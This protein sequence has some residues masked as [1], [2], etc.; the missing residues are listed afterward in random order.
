MLTFLTRRFL[1]AAALYAVVALVCTQIPL[2]NYLGYEYS[3]VIGFVGAFVAGF[4][5]IRITGEVYHREEGSTPG[6]VLDAFTKSVRANLLL[7]IIPLIIIL[8][9][10][11]FVK[12]CSLMQGFAFFLLLPMVSVLFGSALGFYCTI[13]Y[14][15]P[16]VMFLFYAAAFILYSLAEGY[17]TPAIFSYNFLYGYFP[18]LSYDEVLRITPSLVFFRVL[19]LG[20]SGLFVWWGVVLLTTTA[21]HDSVV[22]KGKTLALALLSRGRLAAMVCVVAV[23]VLLWFNRGE[24][25]WE[26]TR[27]FIQSKLGARYDTEHFTIYYSGQV[28]DD[29]EIKWVAAEHEFRLKQIAKAF[30]IQFRGHIESYIYPSADVK[31]KLMGAGNTNIAKPWSG[32]IHVTYQALDNVLKHELVHVVAGQFGM[33]VIAANV[34]TGIV[35]GL[36]MAVEWEWG[37]KTPHQYAA[38]MKAAGVLPDIQPLMRLTGFA[39]RS[40]S[41]SYVA[42]GSFCRFLIDRYG[43]RRMAQLYRTGDFNRVYGLSIQQLTREWQSYLSGWEISDSDRDAVDILF[44]RPPLFGKVCARVVADRNSEAWKKYEARE[45]SEAETLYATSYNEGHG[46]DALRGYL[47]SALSAGHPEIVRKVMDSLLQHDPHPVQYLPL[48]IAAGDAEWLSGNHEKAATFFRRGLRAELS[49]AYDEAFAVRL[50]ALESS[51]ADSLFHLYFH[52]QEPDSIRLAVLDRIP[53]LPNDRW[54]ALYLKGR[55]LFRMKRYAES[56]AALDSVTLAGKDAFLE[57]LRLRMMGTNLFRLRRFQEARE[58]FWVSLNYYGIETAQ[59]EM[60]DN[61]DRSEWMEK[62]F[63]P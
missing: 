28:I 14:S 29:E 59:N 26:S 11:I 33:P 41:V 58:K 8:L 9:A 34:S 25:G 56:L 16:R 12:N 57:A 61:V 31:Q 15:W 45:Y 17:W 3:A 47:A 18:G 42:S 6:I 36:A 60:N 4:M 30:Y 24:I 62:E 22:T 55:T 50:H 54:I 5:T 32:Q 52:S 38:A 10:V 39:A 23:C 13:H 51:S 27:G 37:S 1:L 53:L 63:S 48:Y 43:M 2:L 20:V 7:L 46:Y 35:E 49:T 21:P 44:R 19:T 40:S